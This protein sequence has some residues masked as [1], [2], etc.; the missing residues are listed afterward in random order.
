MFLALGDTVDDVDSNNC[1]TWYGVSTAMHNSHLVMYVAIP[2]AC[3]AL[4][5]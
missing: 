5:V 4:C 2:T 1:G 3:K